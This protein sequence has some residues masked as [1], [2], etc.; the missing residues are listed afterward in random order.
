MND[1][2]EDIDILNNGRGDKIGPVHRDCDEKAFNVMENLWKLLSFE[3]QISLKKR[4]LLFFHLPFII[5]K[6]QE[7]LINHAT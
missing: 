2:A 5:F 3:F 7:N 4:K 1:W 6:F